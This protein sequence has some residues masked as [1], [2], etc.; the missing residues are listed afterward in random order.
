M[1][2][3]KRHKGQFNQE[4]ALKAGTKGGMTTKLTKAVDYAEIG[5][6]GAEKRWGVDK[7]M[8]ASGTVATM[9]R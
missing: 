6:R 4:T 2:K 7:S 1:T 8:D 9:G 3:T 5:R